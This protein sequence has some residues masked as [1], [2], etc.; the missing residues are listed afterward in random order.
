M[1]R[2]LSLIHYAT[3]QSHLLLEMVK[4]KSM[5]FKTC[6]SLR[7]TRNWAYTKEISFN[8]INS[9]NNWTVLR[10]CSRK[11]NRTIYFIKSIIM[12]DNN[13]IY[14]KIIVFRK[15]FYLHF[16]FFL[17]KWVERPPLMPTS[18]QIWDV[19]PSWHTHHAHTEWITNSLFGKVLQSYI[20]RCI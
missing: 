10:Q 2:I 17:R 3:G 12:D 8:E 13:S 6:T 16:V 20:C 18:P 11:K 1:C 4:C 7:T 19:E 9:R 5:S 14:S 15:F